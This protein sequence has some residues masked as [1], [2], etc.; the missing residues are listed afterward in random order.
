MIEYT[1]P[2]WHSSLTSRKIERRQKR[3]LRCI[4]GDVRYD[5][6]CSTLELFRLNDGREKLTEHFFQQLT[7]RTVV[8]II[9]YRQNVT[10]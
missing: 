8:L 5:E 1:C 6:A 7:H 10:F 2:V 3:A 9:C 4:L